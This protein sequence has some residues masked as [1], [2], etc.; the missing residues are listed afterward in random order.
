MLQTAHSTTAGDTFFESELARLGPGQPPGAWS[1]SQAAAYCRLWARRS[2]ENFTVASWLLPRRL[3]QDFYNVYAYCRWADNLADELGDPAESLRLLDWWQQQLALCYSGRPVHPVLLAL[4]QTIHRH[5][6]AAPLFLDLLSAFRQ[7]QSVRRYET[8]P[9]LLDYCRRSANPVGRILLQLAGIQ[10]AA[11]AQLSDHLC[12]ALQLT[13]FCQD[14]ARDTAIDRIYAPR[15]LWV[16]HGV[17]ETMFLERRSTEPLRR[18]LADWVAQTRAMFDAG[19]PLVHRVPGWLATDID[20]FARGGEAVLDA[21]QQQGY[22]VWTRRP[23]ISK[24]KKLELLGRSLARRLGS[25][26]TRERREH[27]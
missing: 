22:D 20:L 15:T 27:A 3:R 4:Q 12:T 16:Q 9:Q 8:A 6:L 24:F 18:L 1:P 25:T 5:Q 19:R 7:D 14:L 2:Y 23:R 11:S 21:I 13:N 17:S 26:R 10:D